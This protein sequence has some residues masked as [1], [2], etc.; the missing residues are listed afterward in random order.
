MTT[1]SSY[2]EEATR[3]GIEYCKQGIP[4]EKNP[5]RSLEEDPE[6]TWTAADCFDVAYRTYQEELNNEEN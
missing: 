1:I 4:I 3:D 2:S 5:Y 6:I